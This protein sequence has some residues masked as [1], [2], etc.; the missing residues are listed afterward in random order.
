[1]SCRPQTRFLAAWTL[2]LAA[3]FVPAAA[4]PYPSHRDKNTWSYEGGIF[5]DTEGALPSGACF[6]MRGR[7]TSGEFFENLKRQD[8]NSG[9]VYRRGNDL[10]SEFPKALHLSLSITDTPCD[11]HL[12]QTDSRVYLTDEMIHSMRLHFFWKRALE[13]RPVR[14]ITQSGGDV[15]PVPWYSHGLEN[16]L[17]KRFEWLVEFDLPSE[18]VP[19]T[20]NLVL[21]L[22]TPDHRLIAR[23]AARM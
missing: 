13:L 17:P 19:L 1:M 6:R 3:A 7:V 10:V 11:P 22:Y 2:T 5:L 14:G 9:T 18:G 23:G 21:M 4:Q 8:S 16:E 12:K 15:R 20:D